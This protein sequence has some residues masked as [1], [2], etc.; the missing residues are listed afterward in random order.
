MDEYEEEICDNGSELDCLSL[1]FVLTFFNL[2]RSGRILPFKSVGSVFAPLNFPK[3]IFFGAFIFFFQFL[4]EVVF[5]S[6]FLATL[7]FYFEKRQYN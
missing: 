4:L 5:L 3:D 2:L 1:D 7:L 6:A